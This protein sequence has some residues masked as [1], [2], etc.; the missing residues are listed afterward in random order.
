MSLHL[1]LSAAENFLKRERDRLFSS[2]HISFLSQLGQAQHEVD[3]PLYGP[4]GRSVETKF[5]VTGRKKRN[6]IRKISFV[7]ANIW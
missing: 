6:K 5:T 2:E 7:D 1:F 3:S 4:K